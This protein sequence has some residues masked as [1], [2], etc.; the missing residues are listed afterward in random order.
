MTDEVV[1]VAPT[2]DEGWSNIGREVAAALMSLGVGPGKA[3]SVVRCTS[4]TLSTIAEHRGRLDEQLIS[5][6]SEVRHCGDYGQLWINEDQH[7]IHLTMGDA[8]GDPD[9]GGTPFEEIA[10]IVT[11]VVQP[12][13]PG[14]QAKVEYD[15]GKPMV[16]ADEW[17][18]V[19][20]DGD[21]G[22]HDLGVIGE[23]IP[24]EG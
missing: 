11:E 8:D 5:A 7:L 9:E 6:L 14:W 13:W 4:S 21:E 17:H 19:E 15:A 24:W 22:W 2:T 3:F 12:H 16:F 10:S 20:D 23:E 18:P 1:L